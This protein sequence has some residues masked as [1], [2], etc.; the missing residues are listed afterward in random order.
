M[1][2]LEDGRGGIGVWIRFSKHSGPDTATLQ[3]RDD[4]LAACSE[5][6]QPQHPC[7]PSASS[8]EPT[9]SQLAASTGYRERDHKRSLHSLSSDGAYHSFPRQR[10]SMR[11]E[12]ELTGRFTCTI[13]VMYLFTCSIVL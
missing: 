10:F 7:R 6:P 4:A 1:I 13:P 12:G 2:D 8:S 5:A 3:L 9:S 11:V